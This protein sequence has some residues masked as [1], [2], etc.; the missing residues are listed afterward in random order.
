MLARV[1]LVWL[2]SLAASGCDS[3][4]TMRD[5]MGQV[6]AIAPAVRTVSCPPGLVP[7]VST[8][9]SNTSFAP[10]STTISTAGIVKFVMSRSHNVGPNPIRPSDAGLSVGFGATAC[11]EFDRAGTY[12]FICTT[13]SFAGTIVV[14]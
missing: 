3:T 6:D 11:L 12:S 13:H 7:V 2:I 9:E 10:P 5:A 1:S 8:S 14:Q 4:S